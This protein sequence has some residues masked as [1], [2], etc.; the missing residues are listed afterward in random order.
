[1]GVDM[2]STLL[3]LQE[4]ARAA[5]EESLKAK[6][7]LANE[8]VRSQARL[9]ALHCL[10]VFALAIMGREMV[11]PVKNILWYPGSWAFKLAAM[12]PAPWATV[13]LIWF[14]AAIMLVVPLI[15]MLAVVPNEDYRKWAEGP[16]VVGLFMGGFGYGI[17]S[18]AAARLDIPHVVAS[19]RESSAMLLLAAL[20]VSC[21]HNSRVV[22][23]TKEAR[24]LEAEGGL[25]CVDTLG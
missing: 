8:R 2:P 9:V 10:A 14:S 5:R 13:L 15:V 17:F 4:D 21:W 7:A 22:R 11:E 24:L 20:L 19:Y 6:I 16:A 1:M 25:L 12:W 3:R 18:V 23:A